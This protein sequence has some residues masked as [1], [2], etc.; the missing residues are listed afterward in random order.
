MPATGPVMPPRH[1]ASPYP[2]PCNYSINCHSLNI[3]LNCM[4]MFVSIDS[5]SKK[6]CF[7]L[8]SSIG[9]RF[10]RSHRPHA[11]PSKYRGFREEYVNQPH[12]QTNISIAIIP[13]A[14]PHTPNSL[15]PAAANTHRLTNTQHT[16]AHKL[17]PYVAT[18]FS[19]IRRLGD[20]G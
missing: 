19:R 14:T 16:S 13:P 6:P 4:P 2:R 1:R 15:F 9:I 18:I 20:M 5:H 12:L 11:A 17:R 3:V 8:S 10:I 7:P